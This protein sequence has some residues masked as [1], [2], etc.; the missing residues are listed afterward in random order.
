MNT[1]GVSKDDVKVPE[2]DLG[3]QIQA[4]FD[5][6]KDLVITIV[7]AMDDEAVCLFLTALKPYK[8]SNDVDRPFLPK[9]PP[10]SNFFYWL[11]EVLVHWSLSSRSTV[12]AAVSYI[13][14]IL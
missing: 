1:E 5:A 12:F 4:D 11:F 6:G 13:I 9:N 3:K 2:G 14:Q 7:S 8:L 10:L